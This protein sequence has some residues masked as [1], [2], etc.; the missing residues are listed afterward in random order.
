MKFRYYF[1]HKNQTKSHC[2]KSML[3][4]LRLIGLCCLVLCSCTAIA[5]R[6]SASSTPIYTQWLAG[7]EGR[8][9]YDAAVLRLAMEKSR[10]E[11]GD[12]VLMT[13]DERSNI[14]RSRMMAQRGD[15]F[16]IHLAPN[17]ELTKGNFIFVEVP[18]IKGL[19]GYRQMIVREEDLQ[20]FESITS[21]EDMLRLRL[22]AG[23]G[24]RW[25]DVEVLR[26]N[27]IKVIET[28]EIKNLFAMLK[29]NRFDFIPLGINE[30]EGT[31]ATYSK[32]YPGLAIARK[33][34]LFYPISTFFVVHPDYPHL[35]KRVE[36]GL[37][38]A[39]KDRSLDRLFEQHYGSVL[40]ELKQRQPTLITLKNEAETKLHAHT[41]PRLLQ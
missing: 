26:G 27:G 16:Q 31:L 18:T 24:S 32:Q 38:Q 7:A 15:H 9:A 2:V 25:P 5:E 21:L 22:E 37:Q 14:E 40:D 4:L 30:I 39:T 8:H 29:V 6:K 36:Y 13:T 20:R 19:L 11:F 12:F 3:S 23:L 35:A 28:N 34:V 17:D 41:Q 33:A 1:T 10:A